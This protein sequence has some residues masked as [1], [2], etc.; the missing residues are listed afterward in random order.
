MN[1]KLLGSAVIM[2]F[3]AAGVSTSAQAALA[4]NAVLNF[5]SAICDSY[6]CASGTSGS[7]FAMDL[8]GNS[9]IASTERTG[10]TSVGASGLML[11]TAQAS[12]LD[13][14]W[15]FALV[16]GTHTT[17]TASSVIASVGNTATVNLS[18]WN[19][20]WDGIAFIPM[21]TG[22]WQPLAGTAVGL[23]TNGV[24]NVVCAVDCATGDT[25]TLDYAATVPVGNVS[26]IRGLRYFLHLQ[27]TVGAG[28]GTNPIPVPAAAWLFG[29]GL[30]GL[31]GI[32]RR[33][34]TA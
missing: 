15:M 2:A 34:K 24:A 29:S 1:K 33:R 16:P 18:G 23:Y 12:G 19:M 13:A 20:T 26:V 25:Y 14:A 31:A 17:T 22:A 9:K 10:I 11:G 32:A 5:T 21:G 27:G 4:S 3:A 28:P 7:W 8:S 30:L 6:G